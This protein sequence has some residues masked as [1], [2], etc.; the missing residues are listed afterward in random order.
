MQSRASKS[1]CSYYSSTLKLASNSFSAVLRFDENSANEK[2]KGPGIKANTEEQ[3]ARTQQEFLPNGRPPP[4]D[5][6]ESVEAYIKNYIPIYSEVTAVS[7]N[8]I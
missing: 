8:L 5:T 7:I 4:I 2:A 3:V 6:A 1:P